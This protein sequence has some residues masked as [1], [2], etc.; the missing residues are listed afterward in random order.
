MKN[1]S[2]VRRGKLVVYLKYDRT[3][4]NTS[5]VKSTISVECF[6]NEAQKYI[7]DIIT[8]QGAE[9]ATKAFFNGRVILN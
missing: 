7:T 4:H 1:I 5:K 2:K 6:L 8:A 3:T 9:E